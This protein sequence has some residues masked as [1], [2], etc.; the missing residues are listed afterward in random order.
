METVTE[1]TEIPMVECS[2]P[3]YECYPGKV[4]REPGKVILGKVTNVEGATR[5]TPGLDS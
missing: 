1:T 2:D 5:F 3:I 4:T